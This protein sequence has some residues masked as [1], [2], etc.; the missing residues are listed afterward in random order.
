MILKNLSKKLAILI[1]SL[2]SAMPAVATSG[3]SDPSTRSF[4]VPWLVSKDGQRVTAKVQSDLFSG[5][6]VEYKEDKYTEEKWVSFLI[7]NLLFGPYIHTTTCVEF[8][9]IPPTSYS[10]FVI[11]QGNIN[12]Y[13]S[14]DGKTLTIVCPSIACTV[15]NIYA[16]QHAIAACLLEPAPAEKPQSPIQSERL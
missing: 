6:C 2:I 7:T 9:S 5:Q 16:F 3:N 8:C 1:L 4:P 10:G 12:A 14:E 11:L 15:K 13:M